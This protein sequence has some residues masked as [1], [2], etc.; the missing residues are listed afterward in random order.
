MQAGRAG[1]YSAAF[2]MMQQLNL[3][4]AATPV[5]FPAWPRDAGKG[6]RIAIPGGGIAGL[7]AAYELNK[8]G[9]KCTVLEARERPGGRVY[10]LRA[11]F[12][13]G[14]YVPI[15]LLSGVLPLS[16]APRLLLIQC[17]WLAGML[18][19]SRGFFNIAVRRITIQGG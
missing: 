9:F 15:A 17:V 16:D 12:A 18:I 1:A 19:V 2:A 3:M 6:L 4:P 7:T 8:A 10:T 11:P 13:Q 14:V 5:T